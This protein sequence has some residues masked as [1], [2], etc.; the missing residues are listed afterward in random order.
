MN[1]ND[2]LMVRPPN[3]FKFYQTG[4]TQQGTQYKTTADTQSNWYDGIVS[5][6]KEA[7]AD[8]NVV[9]RLRD[10]VGAFAQ[11][12]HYWQTVP[13]TGWP[14]DL[15]AQRN[16]L[17]NTAKTI[18]NQ[19]DKTG[20]EYTKPDQMGILPV[21]GAA[22]AG[23]VIASIVAWFKGSDNLDKRLEVYNQQ[24]T[25]GATHNQAIQATNALV[26]PS[27][28]GGSIGTALGGTVGVAL[29]AGGLL[30][31]LTKGK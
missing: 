28:F 25:Q 19:I 21:I 13:T 8:L 29:I 4:P 24:L 2:L 14:S 22:A 18:F 23:A 31:Y 11:K 6:V 20:F 15:V 17:L 7:A 3:D 10:Y 16:I 26:P 5:T 9:Q 30:W 12:V 1:F 27:S